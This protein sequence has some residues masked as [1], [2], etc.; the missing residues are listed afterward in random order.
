MADLTGNKNVTGGGTH[1]EYVNKVGKITLSSLIGTRNQSIKG[2]RSIFTVG[3]SN[4]Y[5]ILK[6]SIKNYINLLGSLGSLAVLALILASSG[7]VRS[8]STV[9]RASNG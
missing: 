8:S 4:L 3:T 1:L 6:G 5:P 9:T 7:V 2:T